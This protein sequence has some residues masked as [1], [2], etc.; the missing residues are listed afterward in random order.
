MISK[1]YE[2]L[3]E[4]LSKS[5]TPNLQVFLF[6]LAGSQRQGL[7]LCVGLGQ[8]R[9]RPRQLQLRRLHQLDLDAVDQ[10]RD[11]ERPGAVVL[12]GVQL[13]PGHHLQQRA[14]QRAADHHDRPAPPVHHQPH[15]HL[16]LS[17]ARR[18]HLRAGPR[19]QQGAHL[20]RHAAHR[21]AHRQ[22]GE[23]ARARLEDQRRR[24]KW[25][26]YSFFTLSAPW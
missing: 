20:A 21:G 24:Q 17:A 1:F 2:N 12:G 22:V 9:P 15:G 16:G 5:K 11:R 25:S 6:F 18:R 23:P 8:R 10:Q 7:D 26:V 14:G 4:L 3:K 13:H 19:G